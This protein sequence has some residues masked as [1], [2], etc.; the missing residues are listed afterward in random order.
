MHKDLTTCLAL[1]FTQPQA[2]QF[3]TE[4]TEIPPTVSTHSITCSCAFKL[5]NT[6]THACHCVLF[7]PVA[8]AMLLPSSFNL[9]PVSEP[10]NV[11]MP[12]IWVE[13]ATP[14]RKPIIRKFWSIVKSYF[15]R[16]QATNCS[17]LNKYLQ[18]L[19]YFLWEE[20]ETLCYL[21]KMTK[22][23]EKEDYYNIL[24]PSLLP[25]FLIIWLLVQWLSHVL[26]KLCADEM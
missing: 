25:L 18:N 12:P 17:S 3:E 2:K 6:L 23:L 10:D 9:Y 21:M 1:I 24:V 22:Q 19:V 13:N 26:E 16:K 15:H 4:L 5:L 11:A 20:E 7:M 14:S 8:I